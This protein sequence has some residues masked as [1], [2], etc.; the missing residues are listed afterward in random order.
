MNRCTHLPI[1]FLS[2]PTSFLFGKKVLCFVMVCPH[3][4]LFL[5]LQL[6]KQDISGPTQTMGPLFSPS[7]LD[8]EGSPDADDMRMVSVKDCFLFCSSDLKVFSTS[9]PV[10]LAKCG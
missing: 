5:L 4:L 2:P 3:T 9:L 7:D 6:S 10:F 1:C 8:L